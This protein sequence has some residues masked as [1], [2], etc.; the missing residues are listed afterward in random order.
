MF[1]IS[2]PISLLFSSCLNFESEFHRILKWI[3]NLSLRY[4]VICREHTGE[5]ENLYS[6]ICVDIQD[7]I[8]KLTYSHS[9]SKIKKNFD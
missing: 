8:I 4:N 2:Q 5:Q 1:G 7:I 6:K 3:K 9:N